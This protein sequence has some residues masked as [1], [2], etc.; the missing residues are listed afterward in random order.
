MARPVARLLPNG[1][2]EFHSPYNA[3]YVSL[4]RERIPAAGRRWVPREGQA[5]GYW[6][7]AAP[8]VDQVARYFSEFFP[9]GDFLDAAPRGAR[10]RAHTPPPPP[11]RRDDPFGV[12]HL[13]E[14]APLELVEAAGRTL[15]K[16]HHPDAKPPGE[17]AL[18]TAAMQR[19][20][21]ALDQVRRLRGVA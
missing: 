11:P 16:L 4:L 1:D 20:N 18:A 21:T 9:D 19:I 5:G 6:W 8:H 2:A 7:V 10:Y 3:V 13:R 12:L 15:A 14:T 17:R